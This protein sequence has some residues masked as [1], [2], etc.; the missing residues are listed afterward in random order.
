M[1][2]FALWSDF[3]LLRSEIRSTE[4]H[5]FRDISGKHWLKGCVFA[6]SSSSHQFHSLNWSPDGSCGIH[7]HV[8]LM[9][10]N[11]ARG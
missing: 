4:W 10:Q 9:D 3:R 8:N 6:S 2:V 1:Y 7:D 5:I 11:T